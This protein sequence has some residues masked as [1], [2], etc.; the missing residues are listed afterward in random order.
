MTR[1]ASPRLSSSIISSFGRPARARARA[2]ICCS[3]PDI[4]PARRSMIA[5]SAGNGRERLFDRFVVSRSCGEAEVL[6][7]GE[8]EEEGPVLGHVGHA[9]LHERECDS[10]AVPRSTERLIDSEH[11]RRPSDAREQA[12]RG[13]ER[14]GLAGSVGPEQR[15]DLA[16]VDA[17]VDVV[18]D[19]NASIPGREVAQLEHALSVRSGCGPR[20]LTGSRPLFHPDLRLRSRSPQ[21]RGDDRGVGADRSGRSPGDDPTEVEHGD[22]GAHVEDE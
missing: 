4:N 5:A 13:E 7:P 11:P 16:G 12:R 3:P 8:S 18:H 17:Q 6:A 14:G 9:A 10:R 1:G 15:D 20:P 21:V 2:S 19:G 22:L